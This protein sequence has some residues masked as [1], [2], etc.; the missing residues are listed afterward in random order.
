MPNVAVKAEPGTE[1]G[2]LVYLVTFNLASFLEDQGFFGYP[3]IIGATL[4]LRAMGPTLKESR[5]LKVW[6][7]FL[8]SSLPNLMS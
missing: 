2:A 3:R 5:K 1:S 8:G 4:S 7:A 6:Y